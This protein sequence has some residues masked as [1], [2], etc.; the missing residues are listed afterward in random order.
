M[1][2]FSEKLACKILDPKAVVVIE[3]VVTIW[4]HKHTVK[5][6]RKP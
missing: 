4:N 1:M 3:S 6:N 2:K 5:W